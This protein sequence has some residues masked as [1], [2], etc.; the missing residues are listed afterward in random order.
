MVGLVQ[1]YSENPSRFAIPA[2]LYILSFYFAFFDAFFWGIGPATSSDREPSYNYIVGPTPN[3][4]L[5]ECRHDVARQTVRAATPVKNG[6]LLS[7]ARWLFC[8]IAG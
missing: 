6:P 8:T 3:S 1:A 5:I 4:F 2:A 7:T